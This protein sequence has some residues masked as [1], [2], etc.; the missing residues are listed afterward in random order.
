MPWKRACRKIMERRVPVFP[1]GYSSG[2]L[3]IDELTPLEA[4]NQLARLKKMTGEK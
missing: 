4:L 1:L 2:N 3:R